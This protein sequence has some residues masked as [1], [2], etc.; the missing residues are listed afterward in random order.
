MKTSRFLPASIVL[1]VLAPAAAQAQYISA[2]TLYVDLRATNVTAG[3]TNWLNE[4][5]GFGAGGNFT[6]YGT[7][8]FVADVNNTAIPG[9][10]RMPFTS[11]TRRKGHASYQ[12][13]ALQHLVQEIRFTA[14]NQAG[15]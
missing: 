14:R 1:A 15:E 2:G 13:V 6:N 4:A 8:T 9:V 7:P 3:T 11:S 10:C 5:S 12:K